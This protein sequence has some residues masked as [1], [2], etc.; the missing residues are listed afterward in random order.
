MHFP[1]LNDPCPLKKPFKRVYRHYWR[2][3]LLNSRKNASGQR[4]HNVPVSSFP[5]LYDEHLDVMI[6]PE[7]TFV[8]LSAI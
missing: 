3:D 6:G 8:R 4:F 2:N 5:T 7:P 1:A